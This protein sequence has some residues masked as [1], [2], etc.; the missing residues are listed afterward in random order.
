MEHFKCWIDFMTWTFFLEKGNSIKKL[1]HMDRISSNQSEILKKSI[2]TLSE[3]KYEVEY[4]YDDLN[5]EKKKAFD[6][7]Y[8][9]MFK[10]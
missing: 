7:L 5:E 8:S 1:S 10:N 3:D 4:E 2:D 6:I 9:F